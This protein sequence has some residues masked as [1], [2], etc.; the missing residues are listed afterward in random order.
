ML[1]ECSVEVAANISI[2]TKLMCS[3]ELD[4]FLSPDRG[5]VIDS[6]DF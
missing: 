2:G 1:S 3:E 6:L 4:A 5:V